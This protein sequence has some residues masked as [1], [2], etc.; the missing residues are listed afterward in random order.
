MR[1]RGRSAWP[2]DSVYSARRMVARIAEEEDK[3]GF[4][5]ARLL[6]ASRLCRLI[7]FQLPDGYRMRF[8]PSS[9][10]TAF[11]LDR[12][13]RPAD[14]TLLRRY[15]RPGAT[16]VDVGANVGYLSLLAWTRVGPAGRV[17]AI[18]AH[19]RTYRF[20]AG[21]VA[22]NGFGVDTHNVAIGRQPGELFFTSLRSD[23]Q[24]RA[25]PESEARRS[26]VRVAVTTLDRLLGGTDVDLLKVDTEGFEV[27][28][29]E[30]STETL[31][32]CRALYIE[33]SERNLR[34]YGRSSRDLRQALRDAGF[35][36]FR[37]VGDRALAADAATDR[38]DGQGAE[39]LF[40]V[41]HE[42]ADELL[43]RGGLTRAA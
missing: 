12:H 40:A 30:G 22:L 41:K 6:W 35:V 38:R 8:Y 25:I 43:R 31:T 23:D 10:S 29:L 19:P 9:A 42:A 4:L 33:D 39:N 14:S 2:R 36:P 26:G 32:R 18:E 28:V 34:R 17:V 5:M 3:V 20:L 21:N 24:N 15:L 11:W 1:S 27:H 13:F 7:T 37:I 16:F